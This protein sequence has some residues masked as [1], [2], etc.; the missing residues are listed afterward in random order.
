MSIT[1]VTMMVYS[2]TP[3]VQVLLG[4]SE[5]VV[6]RQFLIFFNLMLT[7]DRKGK[8]FVIEFEVTTIDILLSFPVDGEKTLK[9]K[10]LFN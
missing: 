2:R 4:H 1:M 7:N 5:T 6:L 3:T 9:C 8:R 10:K